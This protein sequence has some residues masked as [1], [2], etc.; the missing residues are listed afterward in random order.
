M[1]HRKCCGLLEVT[2]HR[3][4]M[5]GLFVGTPLQEEVGCAKSAAWCLPHGFDELIPV[6]VASQHIDLVLGKLSKIIYKLKQVSQYY[7][8]SW[9]GWQ[10]LN[11]KVWQYS[12]TSWYILY[13]FVSVCHT[14]CRNNTT[15]L[16][17]NTCVR[18]TLDTHSS[19]EHLQL[20]CRWRLN[21]HFDVH[22]KNEVA[23][24]WTESA[25]M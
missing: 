11:L 13:F 19:R 10:L 17:H 12:S 4:L 7:N 8:P 25:Y 14:H 18:D 6:S 22:R 5:G 23:H 15:S 16:D 3:E 24:R 9:R 21:C 2:E 1:L 20:V